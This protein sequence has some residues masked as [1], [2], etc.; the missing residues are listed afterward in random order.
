MNS[1]SRM[2][3]ELA[4]REQKGEL[5]DKVVQ[6]GVH[7]DSHAQQRKYAHSTASRAQPCKLVLIGMVDINVTFQPHLAQALPLAD[8]SAKHRTPPTSRC[9]I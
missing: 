8:P 4:D 9:T 7:D 3:P 5:N 1:A 2:L 6:S